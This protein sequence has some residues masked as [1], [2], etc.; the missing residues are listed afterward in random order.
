MS[1]KLE[2][3][4]VDLPPD[5]D[6]LLEGNGSE[7]GLEEVGVQPV[8]QE[9]EVGEGGGHPHDLNITVLFPESKISNKLI[10]FPLHACFLLVG[11]VSDL[12][13]Q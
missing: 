2:L 9:V 7:I 10:S 5:L 6:V 1:D 12:G 8:G 13:E 3:T 4:V 11:H